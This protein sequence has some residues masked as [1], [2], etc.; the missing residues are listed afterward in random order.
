MW[1]AKA[2]TLLAS[3]LPEGGTRTIAQVLRNDA[4]LI[5]VLSVPP[6]HGFSARTIHSVKGAEFPAVCLVISP[7]NAK[8]IFDFLEAGSPSEA[9]EELRKIYVGASRAQRLLAIAA[10]NSQR[11]RLTK[12]FANGATPD[13]LAIVQL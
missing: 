8:S 1:L 7:A 11:Q 13:M 9:A 5:D 12:I 10:P 2:R 4:T 6:S 3:K